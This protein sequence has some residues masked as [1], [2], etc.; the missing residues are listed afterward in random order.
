MIDDEL[1]KG[2]QILVGDLDVMVSD[3]LKSELQ[4]LI[5]NLYEDLK[6]EFK[7]SGTDFSR[8]DVYEKTCDILTEMFNKLD[9]EYNWEFNAAYTSMSDL[10]EK[11]N[12]K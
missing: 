11:C 2:L 9:Q 6:V 10:Y 8:A 7:K 12:T 4:K 1:K 3:E 5:G